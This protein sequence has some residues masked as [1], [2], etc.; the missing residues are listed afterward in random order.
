L[1]ILV[2]LI[3]AILWAAVLLPPILR[4][5]NGSAGGGAGIGDFVARLGAFAGHRGK[6]G[7]MMPLSPIMGPVGGGGNGHGLNG[8][9]LK[10]NGHHFN[11]SFNGGPLNGAALNGHAI[12][13]NGNG[14]GIGLNGNGIGPAGPVRVPSSMTPAQRRRRDI[15]IGVL[16]AAGLTFCLALFTRSVAFWMLNLLADGLLA[17]YVYMLIQ[18]TQRSSERQTK[19]RPLHGVP[20]A[21]PVYS[22]AHVDPPREAQV[23]VLRKTGSY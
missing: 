22:E 1:A 7:G 11:G 14:N 17:G 6:S 5:R 10:G 4:S 8:S 15:L 23:L 3:L 20:T 16:A 18:L 19:V 21:I 12:N 2:I 13:G 9:S